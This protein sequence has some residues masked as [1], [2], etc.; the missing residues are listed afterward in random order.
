MK[1]TE[2]YFPVVLFIMLNNVVLSKSLNGVNIKMKPAEQYFP[3]VLFIL[4]YK[5]GLA[6]EPVKEILNC[7]HSNKSSSVVLFCSALCFTLFSKI[8]L[9]FFLNA[10][11]GCSWD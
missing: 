5:V 10:Y 7:N 9:G 6:F 1:A 4:L 2:Q 3:V 8:N 11:L